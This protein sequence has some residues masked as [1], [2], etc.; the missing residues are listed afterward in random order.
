[1][2]DYDQD[3][4]FDRIGDTTQVFLNDDMITWV[5]NV[6]RTFHKAEPHEANPLIVKDRSWGGDALLHDLLFSYSG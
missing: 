6:K 4:H 5:Q 3:R 1:M 2:I